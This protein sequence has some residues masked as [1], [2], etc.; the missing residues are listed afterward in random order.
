MSLVDLF[1]P[2]SQVCGIALCVYITCFPEW[3]SAFKLQIQ[4]SKAAARTFALYYSFGAIF[5]TSD[6]WT[7][8]I[9]VIC[10]FFH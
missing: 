9:T 3:I 8:K 1:G 10:V 6:L 7:M 5:Y 2:V 4:P